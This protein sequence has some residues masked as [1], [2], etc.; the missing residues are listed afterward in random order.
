MAG[1]G[2]G[3]HWAPSPALLQVE[4]TFGNERFSDVTV[5]AVDGKGCDKMGQKIRGPFQEP[6]VEKV[7]VL[8]S[9]AGPVL[10]LFK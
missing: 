7:S 9:V 1:G 6:E 5:A 2:E 8:Q 3:G 10:K 4:V